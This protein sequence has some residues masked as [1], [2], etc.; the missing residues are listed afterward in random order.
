MGESGMCGVVL[1]RIN[2]STTLDGVHSSVI[3]L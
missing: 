2:L 3:G 1:V